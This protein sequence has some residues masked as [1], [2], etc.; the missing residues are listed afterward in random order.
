M[1]QSFLRVHQLAVHLRGAARL[2]VG[3]GIFQLSGK[4]GELC[5]DLLDFLFQLMNPL[6]LRFALAGTG[7]ALLGFQTLLILPIKG[8]TACRRP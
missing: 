7:L 1:R 8:G 3:R 4:P 6:L 2:L 5:F